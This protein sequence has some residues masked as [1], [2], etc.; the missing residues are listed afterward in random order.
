[1][2]TTIW[3]LH[4]LKV[5]VNKVHKNLKSSLKPKY[6]MLIYRLHEIHKMNIWWKFMPVCPPV[7]FVSGATKWV[8]II[9]RIS[10]PEIKK[11]EYVWNISPAPN[12]NHATS[13]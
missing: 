1:M 4:W 7:E 11:N 10:Y 3:R 12:F 8:S 13:P 6:H 9:F 5:S 2:K